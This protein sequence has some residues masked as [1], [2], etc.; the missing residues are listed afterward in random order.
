LQEYFLC[1]L[2]LKVLFL[3]LEFIFNKTNLFLTLI[4]KLNSKVKFNF[5]IKKSLAILITS[6]LLFNSSGYIL[7]YVSSLHFVKKYII[8]AID[9]NEFDKDIFLLT[10]SK[11]DID[12]GKVS[13]QWIHSREFRFNGNMYD[14]KRNLSDEDSIRVYCYFD[15]K[16]NLL[17]QLFR[18]FAK[19]ENDKTKQKQNNINLLTFIGLFFHS[20]AIP[21][22]KFAGTKITN[23]RVTAHEQFNSE[24]PT[25]PPQIFLA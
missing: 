22:P 7:L 21:F 23:I 1:L 17:E 20:G 24:V 16:E 19:S 6:L 10:L 18:Q 3:F 25:P 9:N 5:P 15:E 8:K 14:I 2:V 13:F 4:S 12:E 11:K